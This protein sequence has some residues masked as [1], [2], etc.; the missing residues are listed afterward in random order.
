MH[1]STLRAD[2]SP[3]NHVVWVGLEGERVLVGTADW[4]WKARD[5]RRDGR[6]GLSVAD[7]A[8]PYRMAE[9][10]GEVLVV[11]PDEGCRRMDQISMNYKSEPFRVAAR[12]G[13]VS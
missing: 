3:R 6:V 13:C 8:N 1:L 10:Q 12:T 11:R 4:W 7:L 9:L 2:G 5:T